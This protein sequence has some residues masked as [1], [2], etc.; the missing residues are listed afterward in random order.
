[1]PAKKYTYI[2]EEDDELCECGIPASVL[3]ND[4]YYCDDCF[5]SIRLKHK[6]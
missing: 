5:S 1:M 6:V 3:Y 4:V 2:S